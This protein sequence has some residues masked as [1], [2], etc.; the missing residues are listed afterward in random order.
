[1]TDVLTPPTVR[2]YARAQEPDMPLDLTQ[3]ERSPLRKLW[4]RKEC[5]LLEENGLLTERYEL[6]FGDIIYKMPQNLPHK[7]AVMLIT[8][9]L[10][11]VFGEAYIQAQMATGVNLAD[12]EINAPEPDIAALNVPLASLPGNE[13]APADIA[14]LV[15]VSASTLNFD[16]GVKARLYARAGIVEYWIADIAGRRFIVH[17]SPGADGYADVTEHDANAE[18]APLARPDALVRVSELL[19]SAPSAA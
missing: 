18:I 16:L 15:E 5:E 10:A 2:L 8:F 6:I 19:P 12:A 4:T 3:M 13:P 14:L 11:R 17:C 7:I 1:M 9:W